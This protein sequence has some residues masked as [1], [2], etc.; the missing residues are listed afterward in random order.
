LRSEYNKAYYQ[1]HK[2][3]FVV[4]AREYRKNNKA[5][6]SL[7]ARLKRYNIS[8]EFYYHLLKEQ[9]HKCPGC[10]CSLSE[11]P[12]RHVHIDHCH[13]TDKVRGIMCHYCNTALGSLK[14]NT[15]TL[16]SLIRYVEK[17]R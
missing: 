17:H 7:R 14:D 13:S 5:V 1:K 11:I 12:P 3:Q 9:D 4:R 15:T 16:A 2:E 10:G 6:V 8:E